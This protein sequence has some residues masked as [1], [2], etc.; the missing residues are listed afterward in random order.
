MEQPIKDTEEF[1][2]KVANISESGSRIWIYPKKPK[3]KYYTKRKIFSY[4]LLIALFGLPFIKYDGKPFVLFNFLERQFIIFGL[5]F[6]PE[7]FFLFALA[8]LTFIVFIILFTVIFGRVFCGWMC[9]Q[10]I[11]MEMVFRRI[12]YAIEGDNKAQIK[13]N[14]A[15]WDRS[16][17]IKKTLKHTIFVIISLLIA[18]TFLAYIIGLDNVV[19]I[20]SEPISQHI[21]GFIAMILF[22]AAFYGVFAFF[23]EQVCT[24][25]CPYGRLQGVMLDKNSIVVSYDNVRG[26]PRGKKSKKAADNLGDCIDCKLCV[27]VC[28][29][30]I[31][32]RNGTQLECVNCTACMD[33]CDEVMTKIS[34]PTGLIRY[35]SLAGIEEKRGKLF[36]GRVWGYTAVLSLLIGVNVFLF[37]TRSDV[38]T[39]ILKSRGTRFIEVDAEHISN[40]YDFE[41]NNKT[42]TDLPIEFKVVGG[43]DH[44]NAVV[45]IIGNKHPIA[46]ANDKVS[47]KFFIKATKSDIEKRKSKVLI[48][49]YSDG[50][51]V[52]KTKTNF[53]GPEK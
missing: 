18:N 45:E 16:K 49:V 7:D 53:L 35:D 31:D 12:E 2:N 8:M 33:A 19:K 50:K 23:R 52:D 47:G 41:I 14:K 27:Q 21:Q 46:K 39:L 37:A 9:P 51:L 1:R 43:F 34:R 22:T 29:T 5:H 6:T 13:L 48:E 24:N 26:E 36:T 40:V 30:G 17:I 25:V 15:P 28:P 20:V 42:N 32:I 38:D 10:T 3:G 11:F 44:G 4:F